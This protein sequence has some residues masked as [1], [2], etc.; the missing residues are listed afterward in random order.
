MSDRNANR[1]RGEQRDCGDGDDQRDELA[2][3]SLADPRDRAR[4]WFRDRAEE[5]EDCDPRQDA[6]A[7]ERPPARGSGVQLTE[8]V[9]VGRAA[10]CEVPCDS[11]AED[12]EQSKRTDGPG[13]GGLRREQQHGNHQ[14]RERYAESKASSEP[15]RGSEL[16]HSLP[17]AGAVRELGG[18]RDGEH[19]CENEA[20]DQGDG[21]RALLSVLSS[22]ECTDSA[23]ADPR[24]AHVPA[25]SAVPRIGLEV[26]A[27]LPRNG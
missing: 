13:A 20:G 12:P 6:V 4:I 2:P 16:E 27:H 19:A 25:A 7:S 18:S 23:G 14:L 5:R 17:G 8:A 15:L 9:A 24:L 26:R 22:S 3:S 21:H 10:A 1:A 11:C